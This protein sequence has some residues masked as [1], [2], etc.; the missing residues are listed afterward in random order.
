[1]VLSDNW[2]TL[3][4]EKENG[5]SV[6]I[7]R[8]LD[9]EAFIASGKLPIRIEIRYPYSSDGEGMP[10]TSSYATIEAIENA[11]RP[12]MEGDKLAILAFQYLGGGEKGWIY[13]ARNLDVFFE[14]LNEALEEMEELPL[15][16]EAERDPDWEE[17]LNLVPEEPIIKEEE[18]A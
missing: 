14:R 16:F 11:L 7:S 15:S 8:R 1:M 17:Y 2:Q 5:T 10:T 6:I 9:L 4:A 18:E 13:Y 12:V 3:L